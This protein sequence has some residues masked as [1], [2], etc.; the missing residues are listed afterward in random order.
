VLDPRPGRTADEVAREA[1]AIVPTVAG[2]LLAA[3]GVFDE[4]WYG[5][6]PATPQSDALMRQAD[7]R[8]RRAPLV[9]A[10]GGVPAVAGYQ[11]P[12]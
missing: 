6:R 11:V 8:I 2:D 9:V 5:G 12:R 1:G 3:A 4:I 10:S 7:D